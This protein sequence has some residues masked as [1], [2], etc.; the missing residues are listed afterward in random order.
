MP[1]ISS[2]VS[3]TPGASWLCTSCSQVNRHEDWW[4]VNV[5][6]QLERRIVGVA[7]EE[8]LCCQSDLVSNN[9]PDTLQHSLVTMPEVGDVI[10][11]QFKTSRKRGRV[12]HKEGDEY[13]VQY[14]DGLCKDTLCLPW[15]YASDSCKYVK[16]KKR[17]K[18]AHNLVGEIGRMCIVPDRLN[19]LCTKPR[20]ESETDAQLSEPFEII[21]VSKGTLA[22]HTEYL[23]KQGK[24]RAVWMPG[25]AIE[26]T[27]AFQEAF[28][29]YSDAREAVARRQ[30]RRAMASNFNSALDGIRVTLRLRGSAA[31]PAK[32]DDKR[33]M[34]ITFPS[35]YVNDEAFSDEAFSIEAF[36]DSDADGGEARAMEAIQAI[37]TAEDHRTSPQMSDASTIPPFEGQVREQDEATTTGEIEALKRIS[38]IAQQVCSILSYA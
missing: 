34:P 18:L 5:H 28:K 24:K 8:E 22:S 35:S 9:S 1:S 26:S 30:K 36:S 27:Y 20:N 13:I 33:E 12:L 29:H 14:K 19:S 10:V 32:H 38:A 23:I 11:V 15:W 16:P 2:T 21:K 31:T 6:C 37:R 25:R 17:Q 7:Y 3:S 4:C